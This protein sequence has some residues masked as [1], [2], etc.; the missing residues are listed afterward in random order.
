M[1]VYSFASA[2]YHSAQHAQC[3]FIFFLDINLKYIVELGIY[4]KT[5]YNVL[6]STK[7]FNICISGFHTTSVWTDER[8]ELIKLRIV[9]KKMKELK[10]MMVLYK[11]CFS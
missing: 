7:V 4:Y 10:L 2:V 1:F 3:L 6:K 5:I 9:K 11:I 8:R